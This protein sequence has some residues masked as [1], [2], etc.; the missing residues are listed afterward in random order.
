[1]FDLFVRRILR[2]SRTIALRLP[3]YKRTRL[4]TFEPVP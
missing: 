2:V 3:D 4:H 1:M